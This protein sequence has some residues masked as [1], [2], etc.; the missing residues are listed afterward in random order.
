[1]AKRPMTGT[2]AKAAEHQFKRIFWGMNITGLSRGKI[3]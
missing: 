3:E 1:M 2:T